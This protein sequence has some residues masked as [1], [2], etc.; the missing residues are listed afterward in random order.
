ML[1]RDE[2]YALL[3][4]QKPEH[5]LVAHALE[6]EAVMRGLAEKLGHDPELWG[7]TGLLHDIDFPHTKNTPEQHGLMA[8]DLLAGKLPDEA[9]YA[10]A[11]HNSEYTG[12]E[13]KSVFDYA[14]RAGESVT[15]LISAAALVRPTKMEGMKPKSL[16]KKMKDKSFAAAVDRGRIRDCEQAGLDLT[17]FLL[18]AIAAIAGVA[19]EVGLV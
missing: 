1:A 5:H 11:A 15:G 7:T 19:D 14:L 2:A 6:S 9:L 12:R 18:V 17:D 13:P 8:Q 10:I 4:D 3:L 16:K